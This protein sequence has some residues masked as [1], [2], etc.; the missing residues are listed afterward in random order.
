MTSLAVAEHEDMIR[1]A[2]ASGAVLCPHCGMHVVVPGTRAAKKYG[3]CEPCYFRAL[4][5]AQEAAAAALEAS[6]E[7]DAARQ[8]HYR[9][10]KGRGIRGR[11]GVPPAF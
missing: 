2:L 7:Y 4:R 9:A 6:A 10:R 8:K 1:A 5:D 3:V 11:V